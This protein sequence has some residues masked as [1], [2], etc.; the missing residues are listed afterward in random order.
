MAH[1]HELTDYEKG[2]IEGRSGMM[3]HAEIGRELGRPRRTVSSFLQRLHERESKENIPRPGRPRKTTKSDDRYLIRTAELDTD[4]PLKELRNAT[5]LGISI[6]TIRQRLREVGIR[7]WVAKKRALLTKDQAKQRYR[8]AVERRHWTRDNFALML[9]SDETL[10]KK[11]NDARRKRVFRRQNK[12][13]KYAPQNIQGQIKGPGVSQMIW[14]CFIGDK[15]GPL[16]FIDGTV[17]KHTYIQLLTENLLSFIKLLHE[18]GIHDVIFQQDN[19][20]PHHA[21]A[22]MDWLKAS[23]EQYAFTIT[24]FPPNSPDLNPIENLWSILKAELYRQ[25]P[26]TMYLPGSGKAIRTELCNRLNKIWWDIGTDLLNKL[27][28]S[29]PMRVNAVRK[30]KGWY[31]EY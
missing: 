18:N 15:L 1:R 10:F 21:K 26:D 29:M 27:I 22:T 5:N 14:G 31:T 2:Q 17:D 30:G 8:W 13:E 9:F 23:A 24:E 12:T 25:Y 3:S 11:N 7:K 28:D 4:Q 16:V 6:Q 20:S 19:A